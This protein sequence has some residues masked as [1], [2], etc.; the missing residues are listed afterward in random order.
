MAELLGEGYLWIKAF[1]L[2]MV[3]AWMAGMMYLPR[4]SMNET[5]GDLARFRLAANALPLGATDISPAD[6]L[7][8]P[9]DTNPPAFG[10]TLT[11]ELP[12]TDRLSCYA[13]QQG[14][15]VTEIIGRRRVE[16]RP[17]SAFPPGRARINCTLLESRGLEGGGRWRWYGRQ[18]YVTGDR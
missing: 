18:F 3:I 15:A 14:R 5:Y 12:D 17:K 8:G 7:I 13:S 6:P 11:G 9:D 4:F 2:I 10:F 16:I 1:H